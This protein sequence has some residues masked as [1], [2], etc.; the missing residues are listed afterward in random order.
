MSGLTNCPGLPVDPEPC[1]SWVVPARVCGFCFQRGR[2]LGVEPNPTPT[3]A[4]EPP[5]K[6][7]K[8]L[9]KLR[10]VNV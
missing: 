8:A 7:P 3:A 2:E 5:S 6:P 4:H 9:R 10:R 1:T